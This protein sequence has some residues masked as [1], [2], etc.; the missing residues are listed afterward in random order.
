MKIVTHFNLSFNF[1]IFFNLPTYIRPCDFEDSGV[2]PPHLV[3]K[4]II[5]DWFPGYNPHL[6]PKIS[7]GFALFRPFLILVGGWATQLKNML[8]KLDSIFP[9]DRKFQK[10]LWN[11]QLVSQFS[12]L[13]SF[14]RKKT[15][16]MH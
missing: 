8:V 16:N 4:Y 9:K 10:N 12:Q 3:G 1:S 15:A 13:P 14:L 11:H 6:P 2:Q 7:Q 5:H